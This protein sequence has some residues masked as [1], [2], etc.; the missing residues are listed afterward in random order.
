MRRLELCALV[1]FLCTLASADFVT[2]AVTPAP[3]NLVSTNSVCVSLN[4][5]T[6]FSVRCEKDGRAAQDWVREKSKLWFGVR[7]DVRFAETNLPG[8]GPEAYRLSADTNGI[9]IESQG[10]AGVRYAM[11]TLRQAAMPR[12]GTLKVDGYILPKLAVE[13]SPALAFRGIH[14]CWFPENTPVQME[15]F[16][17]LA[18]YY[19][20]NYAVIESWGVFRS[21]KYPWLGWPDGTMTHREIRRLCGIADDLGITLIPQVNIFGHASWSRS[22]AGKHA[23]LDLRPEYQP[24][25]EPNSGWNWC[26]SNPE[27]RKVL[28]DFVLEMHDAF[29]RPPYFH[30]GCDEAEAMTCPACRAVPFAELIAGHI[31]HVHDALA[32]RGCR[33]MMWQDML[34]K[35]GDPRWKGFYANANAGTE[36]LVGRLPKD[37]VICDWF[38]EGAKANYPTLD[39]FKEKGFTVLVCP[40]ETPAG[41]TAQGRFAREHG[42]GG[43]L[44]TTWHHLYGEGMERIFVPSANA[45][46]GATPRGCNFALNLRQ[47]GWDIPVRNQKDTGYYATQLPAETSSPR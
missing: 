23:T 24:L 14:F 11:Y 28:T 32:A 29:G 18:A 10:L 33:P 12:R 22:S 6:S 13:D 40:W 34:L 45:A 1:S 42:L 44:A 17:R 3:R 15:C 2:P 35:Q 36:A 26:L 5:E 7:P 31:R 16:I 38:Y 47:V 21:E 41:T 46:W 43:F 19:K 25:F 4:D 37:T 27:A 9:L 8:L 39:Y 30:I 20:F